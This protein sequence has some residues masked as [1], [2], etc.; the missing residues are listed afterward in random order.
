VAQRIEPITLFDS[1]SADAGDGGIEKK[2]FD[3]ASYGRQLGLIT[4]VLIDLAEKQQAPP[5]GA[6]TSLERLKSIRD[7][8]ETIKQDEAVSL[9][10]DIQARAERLRRSNPS[11]F[12]RLCEKLRPLLAQAPG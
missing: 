4:E 7:R 5:T 2:A 11:E 1:I 10:E 3:V 6:A 9:A 12:A 8:I